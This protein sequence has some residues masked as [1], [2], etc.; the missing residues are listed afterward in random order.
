[1]NKPSFAIELCCN[2]IFKNTP[3]LTKDKLIVQIELISKSFQLF[4]VASI[5]RI[6]DNKIFETKERYILTSYTFDSH[7]PCKWKNALTLKT[8]RLFELIG[9]A[10][11]QQF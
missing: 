7:E 6:K 2:E 3:A 4:E 8:N 10:I 11:D 1:M 5:K 9:E